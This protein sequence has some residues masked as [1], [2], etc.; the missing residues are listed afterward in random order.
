[1]IPG[2]S[3]SHPPSPRPG[4]PRPLLRSIAAGRLPASEG[5]QWRTR[6]DLASD[7]CS[8]RHK[9]RTKTELHETEPVPDRLI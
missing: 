6:A 2:S 5:R 1:M 9:C 3:P 8:L 4:K 7:S